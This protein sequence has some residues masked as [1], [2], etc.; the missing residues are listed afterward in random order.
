MGMADYPYQVYSPLGQL[1]MEAPADCRYPKDTELR[2]LEA[3]YTIRLHGKR[4]TK[5]DIRKEAN[6][7]NPRK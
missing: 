2:M 7:A 3:G 6:S 4:L 1:V 5:A